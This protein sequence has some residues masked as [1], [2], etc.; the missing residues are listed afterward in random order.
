MARRR[1]RPNRSK[2]PMKERTCLGCDVLFPSEGA[3][4]RICQPCRESWA[5]RPSPAIEYSVHLHLGRSTAE[6]P[7]A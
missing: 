2:V 7:P 5:S 4:H 1:D 3:H 6:E